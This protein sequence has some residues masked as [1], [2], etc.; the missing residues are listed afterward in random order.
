M[1]LVDVDG[2]CH[3]IGGLR[4]SWTSSLGFHE[5]LPFSPEG[6]PHEKV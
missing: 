2:I 3:S 1:D 5:L 6:A 4:S